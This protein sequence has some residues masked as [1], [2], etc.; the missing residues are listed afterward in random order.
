MLWKAYMH[1]TLYK[2]LKAVF[3]E[4]GGWCALSLS[5]PLFILLHETLLKL[6]RLTMCFQTAVTGLLIQDRIKLGS[7]VQQC[8][9]KI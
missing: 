1:L 3:W 8:T 9:Y 7:Y 2:H 5:T 4:G 6:L